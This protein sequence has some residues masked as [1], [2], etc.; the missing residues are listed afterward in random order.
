MALEKT[1]RDEHVYLGRFGRFDAFVY[2]GCVCITHPEM[3]YQDAKDISTLLSRHGLKANTGET[4]KHYAN[5]FGFP[6]HMD[7]QTCIVFQGPDLSYVKR[8]LDIL[9]QYSMN[10]T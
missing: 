9:S 4:Y 10:S 3:P 5:I 7:D 6:E 2:G 8:A 1:D